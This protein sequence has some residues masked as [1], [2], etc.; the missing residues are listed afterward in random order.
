M[1]AGEI[2]TYFCKGTHAHF[3]MFKKTKPKQTQKNVNTNPNQTANK[4][5]NVKPYTTGASMAIVSSPYK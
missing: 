5:M 1:Y 3:T 4:N 2:E